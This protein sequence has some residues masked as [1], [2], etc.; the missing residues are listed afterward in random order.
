MTRRRDTEEAQE[1][2]RHLAGARPPRGRDI[3]ERALA[4][5][6]GAL[7]E[8]EAKA[9]LAQ[10]GIPTPLGTVARTAEEAARTLRALGRPAVLKALG[11]DIQHK[12]D[13]GLI[14]LDVRDE[15]MARSEFHRLVDLSAGRAAGVLVEEMVPHERELLVGMRRDEQFGL[16]VA[17]GLGGIFTE[18]LHDVA[19]ALAPLDEQ[20]M[21]DLIDQLG[22]RRLLGPVRGLPRVDKAELARIIGAV[23]EMA[24]DH[25]ELV[26]IDVNPLLVSGSALVAADALV[27][28]RPPA[29]EGKRAQHATAGV[30]DAGEPAVGDRAPAGVLGMRQRPNLAAVF[31]PRGVAIIGA[32][33]DAA[34]WGGSL[35]R[36]LL[37]GGYA[38]S[39][40]P[41]NPRG[42]TIFGL[43]A[44]ASLDDL[45]GGAVDLAIVALGAAQAAAVVEAC[46]RRG[47]PAVMVIAAGFGEAGSEGV[48]LEHDLSSAATAGGVTL[49]GPN[50]MGVLANSARLNAVGFV[51]LTPESGPLSVVSQ[52]GNIGTQLLMAAERRGVGIEK[53][54][55]TGNQALTDANDVL[56]HL[57]DDRHTGVVV[58]YVEGLGDGRRFYEVARRTTPT[59]PVVV[60]R[61]GLT[62][63]GR[64]AASSHTGAMAGSAEVFRAAARQAGVIVAADP[65]EA[66]D[67]AACLAY[68]PL[69]LGRRVAVVT[70][71]GGWGVLTA[72]ALAGSDLRLA[73][74]PAEVIAGIDEL[75]PPYWSRGNPVDLVAS[76]RGGVPERIIQLVAGCDAVDAILTLALVG[77]PVTG[78]AGQPSLG[79]LNTAEL[80]LLRHIA[81]VMDASGKPII[82]VPLVPVTRS[83]FAATGAHRPVLLPTPT[84]AVGA[85]AA[86]ASYAQYRQRRTRP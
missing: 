35:M 26:E 33:E 64:R 36:N 21:Y 9:L 7:D 69:P 53:F 62:A 78:R 10:Y 49:V 70:L 38:G 28:L 27:I 32:S 65:D 82:S 42:G 79:E 31:A 18:V 41:V 80:A 22:A 3:V 45:P 19:F 67:I 76:I 37:D 25:P 84:A 12:S 4:E 51:S 16:V 14:A 24:E 85:L 47:M 56:E 54:I 74:L 60:M 52:S 72:D 58:M 50:C 86:M 17:F 71:G 55:S 81:T 44:A 46:G 30:A 29:D 77:S 5:G 40:Y 13:R 83:V 57:A 48:C 59:K 39:V 2:A 23:V 6:T 8:N 34:K 11:A 66:L 68:V 1:R 43:P 63:Y 20:D 75:L 73:D 15:A 61:G